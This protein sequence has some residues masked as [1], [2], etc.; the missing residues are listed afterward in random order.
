MSQVSDVNMYE[1]MKNDSINAN[2]KALLS[3]DVERQRSD[4]EE[5]EDKRLTEDL[6]DKLLP[7]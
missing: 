7:K 4:D 6:I 3:R 2:N 5:R 1:K